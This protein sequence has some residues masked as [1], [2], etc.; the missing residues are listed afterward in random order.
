MIYLNPILLHISFTSCMLDLHYK[1]FLP[2][3]SKI[4]PC[5]F[6]RPKQILLHLLHCMISCMH[7]RRFQY[8]FN[9]PSFPFYSKI[10]ERGTS[11]CIFFSLNES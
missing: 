7:A 3:H 9:V 5:H 10:E 2:P 6:K 8:I 11:Q 1:L 4:Y